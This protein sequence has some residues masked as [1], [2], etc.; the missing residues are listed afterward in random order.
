MY[1]ILCVPA[2][3]YPTRST[4]RPPPPPPPRWLRNG[5]AW[6]TLGMCEDGRRGEGRDRRPQSY[7]FLF[8]FSTLFPYQCTTSQE[9][10][11][12]VPLERTWNNNVV[13]CV[14]N[15]YM[16][17]IR[18]TNRNIMYPHVIIILLTTAARVRT[19][20][21]HFLT[22]LGTYLKRYYRKNLHDTII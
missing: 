11:E 5:R 20:V 13:L 8:F 9:F 14:H 15:I 18:L 6:Q 17:C 3:G 16:R 21:D 10:V 7:I 22:L 12:S 1:N 4:R 2:Q 19:R